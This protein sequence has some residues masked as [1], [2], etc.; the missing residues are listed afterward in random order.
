MNG[1]TIATVM[2][3]MVMLAG[4]SRAQIPTSLDEAGRDIGMRGEMPY[5]VAVDRLSVRD[6]ARLSARV[7]GHLKLHQVVLRSGVNNG[8]ARIRV[9]YGSLRGW[10]DDDKLV[11]KLPSD[12]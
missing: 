12:G 9:P 5:F 11:A 6:G 7:V 2:L 8:Y 1:R 10:V 3:A 4:C